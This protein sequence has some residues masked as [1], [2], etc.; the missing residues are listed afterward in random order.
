MA[1]A[2]LF[3]RCDGTACR[4]VKP[5]A[6]PRRLVRWPNTGDPVAGFMPRMNNAMPPWRL[7]SRIII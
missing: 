1:H 5:S 7:S 2:F 6:F 3:G 4:S